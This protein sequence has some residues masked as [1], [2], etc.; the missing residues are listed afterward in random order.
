MKTRLAFIGNHLLAQLDGTVMPVA[1]GI[2]VVWTRAEL[3]EL[4]M[5]LTKVVNAARGKSGWPIGAVAAQLISASGAASVVSLVVPPISAVAASAEEES[6]GPVVIPPQVQS[7]FDTMFDKNKDGALSVPEVHAGL[8]KLGANIPKDQMAAVF[9]KFD[10][11][12]SFKL[13]AREFYDMFRQFKERAASILPTPEPQAAPSWAHEAQELFGTVFD[14]NADGQLSV[15][16]VHKGLKKLGI[17]VPKEQM[18]TLFNQFDTDGNFRL[19]LSEFYELYRRQ[20]AAPGSLVQAT[21]EASEEE[22]AASAEQDVIGIRAAFEA[23]D[24]DGSGDI[25]AEELCTAFNN[26]GIEATASEAE[27][28]L[29]RYDADASG[30]IDIAEF[31]ALIRARQDFQTAGGGGTAEFLA[32]TPASAASAPAALPAEVQEAFDVLDKDKDGA[33][34]VLEVHKGLTA[35][36]VQKTPEEVATVFSNFDTDKDCRLTSHEFNDL[37][38]FFS[39]YVEQAALDEL[40]ATLTAIEEQEADEAAKKVLPLVQRALGA[41]R[42]NKVTKMFEN[43]DADGSGTITNEEFCERLVALG[44]EQGA[45]EGLSAL[46]KKIDVDND[47]TI[48][49]RELTKVL[50]AV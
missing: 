37:F 48:T 17:F 30:S 13:D 19:E 28:V 12:G 5:E 9:K 25:D 38:L 31:E 14:R 8:T 40:E 3:V 46:F 11:D 18:S 44:I 34:S 16:E 2:E 41:H 50:R 42:Y 49:Y 26:L 45:M 22:V 27:Q 4:S 20:A 29:R 24:T 47:S 39:A 43:L 33:L 21:Q 1:E 6:G 35:L 7:V 15:S 36:G 32:A 10:G 23:I